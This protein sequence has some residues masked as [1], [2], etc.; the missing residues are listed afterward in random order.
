MRAR[1]RLCS[2]LLVCSAPGAVFAGDGNLVVEV[3]KSGVTSTDLQARLLRVP[4]YQLDSLGGNARDIKRAFVNQ[5][6]VP[7]LLYAEEARRRKLEETLPARIATREVLRGALEQELRS[8][9]AKEN[10]VT[11][12]EVARYYEEHKSQYEK[13]LRLRLFRILAKTESLA[14]EILEKAKNADLVAWRE[15][16]RKHSVDSATRERGGDLG[17]VHPDGATDV[18]RVRVEPSLYEAAL[19]VENGQLVAE[20]VPEGQ[21]FAVIWRRGSLDASG[22]ALEEHRARIKRLLEEDR[23]RRAVEKITAAEKGIERKNLDLLAE[24]ELPVFGSQTPKAPL[25]IDATP[26][27]SARPALEP[28]ADGAR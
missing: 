20:P 26:H 3:G 10:P 17:F 24:L 27:S 19:G 12:R 9:L 1:L 18:P 21:N 4:R 15:L 8:E 28:S 7:E 11:E 23:V 5:V 25:F 13:P 6:V 16:A 22:G 14:R 2:W